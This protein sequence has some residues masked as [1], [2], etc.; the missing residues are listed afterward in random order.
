MS[1]FD[2]I[3]HLAF[4]HCNALHCM[5]DQMKQERIL[6]AGLTVY[7][8]VTP[9]PPPPG[10]MGKNVTSQVSIESW[11]GVV[12][13]SHC[14]TVG[15]WLGPVSFP[16]ISEYG[17]R[18]REGGRGQERYGQCAQIINLSPITLLPLPSFNCDAHIHTKLYN[19]GIYNFF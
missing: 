7:S 13:T 3:I 5:L 1:R 2:V 9:P 4:P 10:T 12:R 16:T 19:F 6:S 15:A 8:T 14:G 17:C 18:T 11:E